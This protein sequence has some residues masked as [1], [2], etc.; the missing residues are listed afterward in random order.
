MFRR[1]REAQAPTQQIGP[2]REQIAEPTPVGDALE[3]V[4]RH[5]EEAVE[6]KRRTDAVM[7]ERLTPHEGQDPGKS[8][9]LDFQI[10][11]LEQMTSNAHSL[12]KN[13]GRV[14]LRS[15]PRSERGY[16]RQ[17]AQQLPAPHDHQ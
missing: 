6:L 15:L 13:A 2:D 16:W 5:G 4:L 11:Y 17:A 10:E 7:E 14:A 3:R 9:S 1:S 8:E 12:A